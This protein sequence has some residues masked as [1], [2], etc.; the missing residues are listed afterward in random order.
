MEL[1]VQE[2]DLFQAYLTPFTALAGDRRTSH[3]LGAP[4]CD[5]IGRE[6]L[7][8]LR[9]D[10][11]HRQGEPPPSR[12]NEQPGVPRDLRCNPRRRP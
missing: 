10:R 3:R 1:R 5:I 2:I 4:V 7:C 12:G 8:C 11:H 6:A 9:H